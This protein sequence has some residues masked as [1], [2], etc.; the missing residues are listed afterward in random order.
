[1]RR[2]WTISLPQS[3]DRLAEQVAKQEH[4]T[5]SELIREALRVYFATRSQPLS[6]AGKRLAHVGELAEF[7]LQRHPHAKMNDTELRES[8]QGIKQ[9]HDRLKHLA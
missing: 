8:F 7:Y 5:K 3:M 9:L 1:M 6:H 2:V 4:R